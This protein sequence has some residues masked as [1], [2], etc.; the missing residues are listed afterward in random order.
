MIWGNGE[1]AIIDSFFNN[2]EPEFADN[3]NMDEHFGGGGI[4]E[5]EDEQQ[6]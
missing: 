4:I 3:V 2:N 6:S 1:V 5:E